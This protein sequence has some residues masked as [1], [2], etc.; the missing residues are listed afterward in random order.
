MSDAGAACNTIVCGGWDAARTG[1][2]VV[3]LCHR[4]TASVPI[5]HTQIDAF[6]RTLLAAY[7]TPMQENGFRRVPCILLACSVLGWKTLQETKS[8]CSTVLFHRHQQAGNGDVI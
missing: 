5:P 8:V 4:R 2:H 3:L 6:H 7:S 1:T